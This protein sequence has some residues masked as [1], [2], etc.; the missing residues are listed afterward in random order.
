MDTSLLRSCD[1]VLCKGKD[2][3]SRLVLWGTDSLYRHLDAR[4]V[5][6]TQE[7]R[8]VSISHNPSKATLLNC[9]SGAKGERKGASR[10]E[11]YGL[12]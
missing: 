12:V 1:I 9:L 4:T 2:F 10:K 11:E 5:L 6:G 3:M 7:R 8:Q